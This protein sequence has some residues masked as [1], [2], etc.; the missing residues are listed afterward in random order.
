MA[1]PPGYNGPKSNW[2]PLLLIICFVLWGSVISVTAFAADQATFSWRAN[3]QDEAVVGYRLY[4][5]SF[6]RYD[7]AGLLKADFNYDFY[8]DFVEEEVCS[9]TS[10]G[11]VCEPYS[12]AQVQCEDLAGEQPKCTLYG[13]TDIKYFAMTAYNYEEESPYTQELKAY[14]DPSFPLDASSQPATPASRQAL[15]GTLHAV[16][17]ILLDE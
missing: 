8:L 1:N 6:S 10:A 16:Y 7:A 2:G 15:I 5:G 11:P 13:L 17:K 4:Y 3:P 9:L 12:D 14:F